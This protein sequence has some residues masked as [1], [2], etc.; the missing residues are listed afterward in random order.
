[1]KAYKFTI[2]LDPTTTRIPGKST[3]LFR[4]RNGWLEVTCRTVTYLALNL[5]DELGNLKYADILDLQVEE[6]EVCPQLT[7]R[8]P[9]ST[10]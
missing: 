5:L 1:M 2:E 7:R 3:F 9:K 8:D 4:K 10:T 6:V